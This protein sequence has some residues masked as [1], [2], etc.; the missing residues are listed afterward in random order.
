[1]LTREE[2]AYLHAHRHDPL[3]PAGVDRWIWKGFILRRVRLP[4]RL[5]GT[6]N[7]GLVNQWRVY[8]SENEAT[9]LRTAIFRSTSLRAVK[10]FIE[11]QAASVA[12]T[13]S[14][15]PNFLE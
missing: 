13:K 15:L 12:K 4:S 3:A 9:V 7:I 2:Q 6:R 5:L 1:M 8:T 10:D 14:R 11:M